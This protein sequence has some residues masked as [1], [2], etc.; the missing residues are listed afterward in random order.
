MYT[1]IKERVKYSM[2]DLLANFGGQLGLLSG[3]SAITCVEIVIVA[4]LYLASLFN[5][6]VQCLRER[7]RA[8][9]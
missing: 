7:M 9:N 1:Q 5:A 4:S 2:A 6:C 8:A 3:F